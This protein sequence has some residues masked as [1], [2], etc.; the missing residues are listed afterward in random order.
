MPASPD[1]RIQR[2]TL[3]FLTDLEAH[4]DR[5]WFQ[6]NKDRYLAAHA[7]MQAF[8]DALIARMRKHDRLA[9]ASGKESLM[10]IY[11]DQRF[12]KDR[13]PYKPRFGGR[14]GRVK[15]ALRGGYFFR[16]QPD[17]RSQITCGFQ[18]P[19]PADMKLIRA[20]IAYDHLTWEKLLHAKAIKKNFGTLTGGTLS[21]APRGF[22]KDHPA[23]DLLRRTQF[24]LRH[25]FTDK[26]VLAPGF[27]DE[28]DALYRSVRPFFDHMTEVLTTDADG[29]SLVGRKR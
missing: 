9:T 13:P 15:P 24:L 20:D 26:E 17:G 27:L 2:A 8:A 29:R 19:E 7:N 5:D 3:T 25:G 28:V 11:T 18:G 10:R 12:H 14:I 16:I 23:I 4:N 21:G 1:G 6:A 22:A